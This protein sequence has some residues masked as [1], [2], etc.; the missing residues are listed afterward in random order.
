MEHNVLRLQINQLN[1]PFEQFI[2]FARLLLLP[3]DYGFALL[4]GVWCEFSHEIIS[5]RRTSSFAVKHK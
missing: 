3:F 2:C 1:L 4:F 5:I